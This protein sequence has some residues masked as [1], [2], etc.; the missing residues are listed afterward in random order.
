MSGFTLRMI[1]SLLPSGPAWRAKSGGDMDNYLKAQ[2]DNYDST[3]L[4]LKSLSKVRDPLSTPLLE[5]LEREYGISKNASLTE[6]QRRSFLASIVTRSKENGSPEELQRRLQEGGF[7]VQVHPNDPAIDPIIILD[8]FGITAGSSKAFA[9]NAA[10]FCKRGGA[11]L[12]VNGDKFRTVNNYIAVA[13]GP[14]ASAGNTGFVAGIFDG[15]LTEKIEYQS[16]SNPKDWPLI[17]FIGGDATKDGDKIT[18]V[19]TVFE[20]KSLRNEYLKIILKYKPLHVWAVS[21]VNFV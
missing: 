4:F 1:K 14:N 17:F 18:S 16:P 2:A 13:G 15:V 20:S 5:E 21:T 6:A 11:E 8:A 19:E 12:I 3:L 7:D 9:G 10:A